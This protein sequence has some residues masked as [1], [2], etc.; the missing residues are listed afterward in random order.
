MK[1][2]QVLLFGLIAWTGVALAI[3]NSTYIDQSGDYTSILVQQDGAGNTVRGVSSASRDTSA[4]M[5]GDGN[6]INIEQKGS[7]NTLGFGIQT[8]AT[9]D[10]LSWT[11]EYTQSAMT[12]NSYVYTVT[13]NNNTTVI[14]SNADGKTTS[15]GNGVYLQQV[16]SANSVS[17]ILRGTTN[18]VSAGV[19]GD[20]NTFNSAIEGAN[21]VQDVFIIGN[22]NLLSLTQSGDNNGVIGGLAG[23]GNSVTLIQR[24]FGRT[25]HLDVAGSSNS[26]TISQ[27]G[28]SD[29][30]VNLR[31]T[32][33]YNAYVV[34]TNTR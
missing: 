15:Y 1:K 23:Y 9:S 5:Y 2:L 22:S 30:P 26:I 24:D 28:T 12:S 25:V 31:F 32:G 21:N 14:D 13:G 17:M 29:S 19:F 3:D 20:N 8:K 33:S 34:N 11:S 27:A 6:Y 18:G 7:G 4:V 10:S 16:G